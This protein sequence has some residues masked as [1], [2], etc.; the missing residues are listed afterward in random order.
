M[1]PN[2]LETEQIKYHIK[3]NNVV[4]AEA[5]TMALAENVVSGLLTEQQAKV[6]IVP[7]AANGQQ[8]LLG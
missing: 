6:V 3:L 1:Q 4:I 5:A 7:V 8:V 2:I